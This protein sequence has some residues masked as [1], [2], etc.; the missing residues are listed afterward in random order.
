[1]LCFGRVMQPL[2]QQRPKKSKK[3][4]LSLC[5]ASCGQIRA[6][7][8]PKKYE[9]FEF[10]DE[11]TSA[12]PVWQ[13]HAIFSLC[14]PFKRRVC[15]S[16]HISRNYWNFCNIHNA[17][18]SQCTIDDNTGNWWCVVS[19]WQKAFGIVFRMS[20][21]RNRF[22]WSSVAKAGNLS[23]AWS[24]DSTFVSFAL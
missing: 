17:Q 22:S 19:C 8:G 5:L 6:G 2:Q 1:M 14:G 15:L 21:P 16:D 3:V 20:M 9:P 4:K 23:T 7:L 12:F 11:I 18:H 24:H 13:L 10:H